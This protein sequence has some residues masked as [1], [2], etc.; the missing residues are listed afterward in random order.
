MLDRLAKVE[1][2]DLPQDNVPDL[3]RSTLKKVRDDG[4]SYALQEY[5]PYP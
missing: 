1:A 4:G 2:G 5:I 3:M